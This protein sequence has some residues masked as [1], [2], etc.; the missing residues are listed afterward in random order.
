MTFYFSSLSL[1]EKKGTIYWPVHYLQY[2]RLWSRLDNSKLWE[3]LLLTSHYCFIL[4]GR[5]KV[6][7]LFF[8]IVWVHFL[9]TKASD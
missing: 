5:Q 2:S 8:L 7:G 6:V 1:A 3:I 9:K 4:L